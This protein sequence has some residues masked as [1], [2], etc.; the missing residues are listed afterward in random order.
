MPEEIKN[1][2]PFGCARDIL[3]E[4]GYCCHL[5]GFTSDSTHLEPL[6]VNKRGLLVV[7]GKKASRQPVLKS[8]KLINPQFPQ[9]MDDGTI[10]LAW[11]WVSSRVYRQVLEGTDFSGRVDV[12][13]DHVRAE[14]KSVYAQM[15]E[16]NQEQDQA[17]APHFVVPAPRM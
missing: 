7:D 9:R 6:V 14:S 13:A 3:D 4:N 10:N 5:V 16:S 8:D 1:Y 11:K 2:C 12:T 17:V 15:V